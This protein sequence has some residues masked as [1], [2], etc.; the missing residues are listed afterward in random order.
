MLPERGNDG[1]NKLQFIP[2]SGNRTHNRRVYSHTLVPLRHDGRK[3]FLNC[4]LE[5]MY[6][7]ILFLAKMNHYY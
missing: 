6:V 3:C 2:P 7:D 5:F 1:I 4:L